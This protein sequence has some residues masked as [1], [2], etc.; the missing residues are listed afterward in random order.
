MPNM[1]PNISRQMSVY[2]NFAR[3]STKTTN[4]SAL[5]SSKPLTFI[6]LPDSPFPAYGEHDCLGYF[7]LPFTLANKKGSSWLFKRD[8]Q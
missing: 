7:H 8:L 4:H 1:M 2:W 3:Q 5:L 6:A